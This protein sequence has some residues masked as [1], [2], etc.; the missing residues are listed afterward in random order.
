MMARQFELTGCGLPALVVVMAK[1]PRAGQVKTR[2][3]PPL[4]PEMAARCHAAFV[5]D[6]LERAAAAVSGRAERE[7]AVAPAG[8]APGL[9]GL[10]AAADWRCVDQ[11][12]EGL[13]ARMRARLIAGVSRGKSVVLI[14]SDSPDLPIDR[15]SRAFLALEEGAEVV[16]GPATDGGYYLIGCR[17]RVPDVF[18]PE[19][20]WGSASVLRETLKRLDAEGIAAVLLDPWPDVDDWPGLVALAERL[21]GE[22]GHDGTAA[23]RST[24]GVLA[25]LARQGLPL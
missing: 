17:G 25:E 10:A 4:S 18:R 11:E 3:C 13:G 2:L 23:P 7:L 19:M 9:R 21:R 20:A 15:I 6:T 24:I 8:A 5:T 12:G 16:V 1:E 14:G 22:P